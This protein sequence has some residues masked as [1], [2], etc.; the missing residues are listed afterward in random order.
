MDAV[1]TAHPVQRGDRDWNDV[2]MSAS[3]DHAVWFHRPLRADD[4][5]LFDMRPRQLI[6][7]RGLATGDVFTAS[8]ELVATV[9]QQ[10][11]VRLRPDA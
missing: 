2:Y 11:L 7:S 3:L 8:G 4:W 1:I 6:G 5:L 9:A 10:G